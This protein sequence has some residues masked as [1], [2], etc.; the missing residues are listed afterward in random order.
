MGSRSWETAALQTSRS[1]FISSEA[2]CKARQFRATAAVHSSRSPFIS[3]EA[4]S[5]ACQSWATAAVHSSRSPFFSSLTNRRAS[6]VCC[7][8]LKPIA[9]LV[10][11]AGLAQQLINPQ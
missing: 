4:H 2:H 7:C 9:E 8:C 10:L 3:F 11:L 5:K 6:P 1:P